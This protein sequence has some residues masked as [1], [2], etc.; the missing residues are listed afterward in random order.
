MGKGPLIALGLGAVAVIALAAGKSSAS[1]ETRPAGVFPEHHPARPG[2]R[3]GPMTDPL[4]PFPPGVTASDVSDD[5]PRSANYHPAAG[6][7]DSRTDPRATD[8]TGFVLPYHMSAAGIADP[9]YS[10]SARMLPPDD[11]RSAFTPS[12]SVK[13]ARMGKVLKRRAARARY[14]R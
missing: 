12:G 3:M 5:D 11:P 1:E 6:G 4:P 10:I 14:A 9:A 13:G 2:D 8:K 7:Y